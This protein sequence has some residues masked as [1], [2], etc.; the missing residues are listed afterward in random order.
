MKL[1]HLNL[2]LL[3]TQQRKEQSNGI[4]SRFKRGSTD[5][6]AKVQINIIQMLR[7]KC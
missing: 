1:S 6:V 5:D 7:R 2:L 4:K 3:A